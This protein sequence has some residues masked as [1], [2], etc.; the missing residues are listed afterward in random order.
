MS[1][2]GTL[3]VFCGLGIL[4]LLGI[5]W[6]VREIYEASRDDDRPLRPALAV[7][8][9]LALGGLGAAAGGL[10][11]F[12]I[13]LALLTDLRH[14]N[15]LMSGLLTLI[16]FGGVI[17][18]PFLSGLAGAGLLKKILPPKVVRQAARM[19]GFLIVGWYCGWIVIR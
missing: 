15:V 2:L 7:I 14:I 18:F 10:L 4:C 13:F 11:W 8:S 17:L 19:V 12:I 3:A 9:G 5:I 1:T 16:A 6:C